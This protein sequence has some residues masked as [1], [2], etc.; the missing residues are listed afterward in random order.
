MEALNALVGTVGSFA[1]GPIMIV[2]LVGTGVLLTLGT[3]V[4]QF[5]KLFHAFKLLVSKEHSGDGDITPFQALM[6]SLSA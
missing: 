6:T 1:W 5:R 3:R 4:V 2:F